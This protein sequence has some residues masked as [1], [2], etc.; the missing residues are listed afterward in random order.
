VTIACFDT[1]QWLRSPLERREI[2]VA[3]L[4]TERVGEKTEACA[5]VT[6]RVAR[7]KSDRT[8]A[9]RLVYENYLAKRLIQP[10]PYRLRVTPYHLLPTTQVFIASR[11]GEVICTVTLIGDGQ[12]GLPMESIYGDEVHSARRDGLY[13]GEVSCLA[14]KEVDFRK[15]LPTFMQLTRVMAQF[16]RAN[17]MDQFLIAAHPKHARF[18]QRFMGME[19]IGGLKEYPSVQNAP[20][21]A[22]CLDFN[23]IDRERPACY[24]G[25]FGAKVPPEML[26]PDVMSPG[27]IDAFTH[28]MEVCDEP[29]LAESFV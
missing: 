3:S 28:V 25:Y 10:N 24:D 9:F 6:Y 13:V 5:D 22:C 20:A 15:F 23:R 26:K 18:Y 8:A 16:A 27:E 11:A 17:N 7:G 19:Q 4:P 29:S 21:V 1:P 14:V 2:M 12:Y